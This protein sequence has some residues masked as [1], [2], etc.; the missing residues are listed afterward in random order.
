MNSDFLRMVWIGQG[1]LFDE[2]AGTDIHSRAVFYANL[3]NRVE[4]IDE[5]FADAARDAIDIAMAG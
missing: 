2:L 3:E 4:P 5:D 1:N